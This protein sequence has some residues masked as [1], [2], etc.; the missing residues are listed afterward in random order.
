MHKLAF[1]EQSFQ[2]LKIIPIGKYPISVG[3]STKIYKLEVLDK[4]A[5]PPRTRNFLL[6]S[7]NAFRNVRR[8][9][10]AYFTSFE[11]IPRCWLEDNSGIMEDFQKPEPDRII[12]VPKLKSRQF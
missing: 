2:L 6:Y 3:R 7:K 8:G 4:T 12:P 1:V 5:G 11:K 10:Q 9:Y